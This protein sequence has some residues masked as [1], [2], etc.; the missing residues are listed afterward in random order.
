MTSSLRILLAVP[1]AAACVAI[2]LGLPSGCADESFATIED[3]SSGDAD[4]SSID[5]TAS[6]ADAPPVKFCDGLVP[7]PA[8]CADFDRGEPAE[9]GWSRSD[10]QPEGSG[11]FTV[12]TAQSKSAPASLLFRS[13]YQPGGG[14][15]NWVGRDIGAS[16]QAKITLEYD[17]F[18]EDI[19]NAFSVWVSTLKFVE[20][21]HEGDYVVIFSAKANGAALE[22]RMP[23]SDGGKPY[24]AVNALRFPIIAQW[25]HVAVV[26]D[27]KKTPPT[28]KIDLDGQPAIAERELTEGYLRGLTELDIGMPFANNVSGSVALR[29]DNV[30]LRIEP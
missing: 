11:T 4:A 10:I 19:A 16:N 14:G 3:A 5:A 12:D 27:L 15:T 6:D 17:L 13:T 20:P 25:T 2:T 18:V 28:V 24:N 21:S 1:L 8:L 29:V 7:A 26:V 23:P 30:V 9:F 22:E